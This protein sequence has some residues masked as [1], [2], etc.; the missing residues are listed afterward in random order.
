[1]HVS[2]LESNYLTRPRV[3]STSS[4]CLK[5]DMMALFPRGSDLFFLLPL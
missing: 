2:N 3:D 4:D 1:M 5:I